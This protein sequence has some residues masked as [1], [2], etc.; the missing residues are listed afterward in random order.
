MRVKWSNAGKGVAS[1]TTPLCCSY[2]KGSLLV[3][4]AVQVILCA[5]LPICLLKYSTVV[6]SHFCLLVFV[7]FSVYVASALISLFS[8]LM[9]SLSLRIVALMQC[10]MLANPLPLFLDTVYLCYLFGVTLLDLSF[11]LLLISIG[12][13]AQFCLNLT[14]RPY[15]VLLILI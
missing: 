13:F 7:Y 5:I 3:A 14:P 9:Y 4:L 10:L 8:L 12:A 2:W 6:L 11:I 1:P 15:L